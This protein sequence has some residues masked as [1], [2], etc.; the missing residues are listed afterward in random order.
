MVVVV[1]AGAVVVVVV[2]G[3]VVVVV[4]DVVV[5][6]VVVDVVVVV[7]GRGRLVAGSSVE[8]GGSV[9]GGASSFTAPAPAAD[10]ATVSDRGAGPSDEVTPTTSQ[11]AL[12]ASPVT[13]HGRRVVSGR[14]PMYIHSAT[15]GTRTQTAV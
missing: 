13:A 11:R 9:S 8:I 14:E 1:V 12:T 7:V 2:G 6:V 4:V 5:E 15:G 3:T 10:A